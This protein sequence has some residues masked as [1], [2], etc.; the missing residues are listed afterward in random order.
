MILKRALRPFKP[1]NA[2]IADI[3]IDGRFS[4]GRGLSLFKSA[5]PAM[6]S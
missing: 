6:D 2:E 3:A 4:A 1:A 5:I